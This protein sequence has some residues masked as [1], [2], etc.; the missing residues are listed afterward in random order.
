MPGYYEDCGSLGHL[1]DSEFIQLTVGYYDVTKHWELLSGFLSAHTCVDDNN[2]CPFEQFASSQSFPLYDEFEY[3]GGRA[4]TFPRVYISTNKHAN[5]VSDYA[6]DHGGVF[7]GIAED[8]AARDKGRFMVWESHNIG[9][10]RYQLI[11]CTPSQRTGA[12][13]AVRECFWS[14]GN[15]GGWNAN[16][17]G[18]PGY[19]NFLHSFAYGCKW[20]APGRYWCSQ[21]GM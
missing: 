2:W 21:Y 8:C 7:G 18:P 5:Y 13:P 10:V 4:R 3:P 17:V 11:N 6:C 9:N 19:V 12:D 14:G 15:F 16:N 20:L 1:G